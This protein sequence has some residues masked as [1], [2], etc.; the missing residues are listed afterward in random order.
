MLLDGVKKVTIFGDEISV[1]ATIRNFTGLSA[2]ADKNGLLKW[3]NS[4]GKKPDK[5]FIVH[6]EESICDEFAGSLNASGYSA[7][8]P[9]CKSAYDLNNGELINAGIK[10]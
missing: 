1:L 10:I 5:V 4:F 7:V 8:A 2:H 6:S 3:I 9:L